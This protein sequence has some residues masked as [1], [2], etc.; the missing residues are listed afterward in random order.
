MPAGQEIAFEPPLTLVLAEHLHDSAVRRQ[1]I[2]PGVGFRHPGTVGDLQHVL[3]AVGVVLVRTEEPKIPLLH[4]ELH[5]VAQKSTHDP[6]RLGNN[7]AGSADLDC[8]IAEIWHP[9][10]AQ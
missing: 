1:M 6:R 4:V 8:V 10:F 3:P 5:H 2:V 9:Q 7:G